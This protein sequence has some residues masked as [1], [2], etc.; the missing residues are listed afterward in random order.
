MINV[1][2]PALGAE[3]LEAVGRVFVSNWV[4]R[5]R[6]TEQFEQAFADYVGVS[7]GR[8]H[9]INSCTEGLFQAAAVLDFGPGDEVILPS[10]SFVGA[11]NAIAVAGARPVFCDVDP[12]TLNA[13][14]EHIE[15]CITPRT[16]AILVLHYGG[17]PCEMDAI[18]AL[19]AA[20]GIPLIEDS[21]CS[22]ASSYHGQACGTI[23]DFGVW[24]F[25]AMKILVTGDGGMVYCR[26]P[27]RAARLDRLTYLGLEQASGF[28]QA[29]RGFRWWAFE[30]SEFG[31][32]SIMNDIA[33]AIGL[34]QLRKLPAFIER[35]RQVHAFYD[36]ALAEAGWLQTP[37]ALPPGVES[38]YYFYWVQAGSPHRSGLAH[39]DGERRDRL[40]AH[41]RERGIYTTFRY[42][43]L[44]HVRGYDSD[45]QLA[46]A[47]LA[48]ETTLC[49][50]QHQGLS[51]NDLGRVV[52]A[53]LAFDA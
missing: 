20:K 26:D 22:V 19:A 49:L 40:A 48:A 11:A 6:L 35:R 24:S 32:R 9:S 47:D 7:P 38:S 14:A 3:E 4:G 29:Q 28:T 53:V 27:E 46:N 42:Y 33:A 50:P 30:V 1:F 17:V 31:R 21:A 39:C 25:D 15:A 5:G 16:K 12:R 10:L 44:H 2:Q 8:L 51:D 13:T 43:P 45:A 18:C 23:G 41:L 52:E 34:E 36:A 37:P